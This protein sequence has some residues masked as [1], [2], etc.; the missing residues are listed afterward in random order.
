MSVVHPRPWEPFFLHQIKGLLAIVLV[1]TV[2]L[3][4]RN[5]L[6]IQYLNSLLLLSVFLAVLG[7][8]QGAV[9][10]TGGLDLSVPWAIGFCAIFLTGLVD[11]S[12]WSAVWAIPAV[13]LVGVLIGAFNGAGVALLGLPPIVVTLAA[14][15]ILQGIA[16]LY[17]DPEKGS[18]VG[19][20]PPAAIWFMEGR[21]L[22]F[23]PV[24]WFLILFVIAGSFLLSRTTFG[25]RVYAVGNSRVVARLSGVRVGRTLM[26]VYMLS[27]LCSAMVGIMLIGLAKQGYRGMGDR[28]LLPAIAV[29]VVGG[30]LITGGRG[31]YL[32]IF[33]GALLL[34]ALDILMSETT[35][36]QA[37][38]DILFGVVVLGAILTLR[39][40]T[41]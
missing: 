1:S 12:A 6:S 13:L 19:S 32:G 14:N 10:L 29:V 30:T 3:F 41:D 15:G 17:V 35:W 2:A 11:G 31:H 38:R 26:S 18:M 7:L 16:L 25:R 28:Y 33:G 24:A 5:V 39:E 9:I 36:S 22:G 37:L 4:G 34:T 20:A 27:G 40:K 8:G 23:S 21:I